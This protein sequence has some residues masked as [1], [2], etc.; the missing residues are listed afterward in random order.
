VEALKFLITLICVGIEVKRLAA[1]HYHVAQ[2]EAFFLGP[3]YLKNQA[4][5][6]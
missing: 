1:L 2:V 6:M 5:Q 3:G 4:N